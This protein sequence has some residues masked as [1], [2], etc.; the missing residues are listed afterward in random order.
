MRLAF[1]SGIGTGFCAE[2]EQLLMGDFKPKYSR[3]RE[4]LFKEVYWCN[5]KHSFPYLTAILPRIEMMCYR[6]N[7]L[8]E[9]KRR[10][11]RYAIF[12]KMY[13][14]NQGSI[15]L[16]KTPCDWSLED[17]GWRKLI[18]PIGLLRYDTY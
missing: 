6:F 1:L 12:I 14:D 15:C 18:I 7:S 8:A 4:R 2:Q 17:S 13:G 10:S 5:I 16:L 11:Y 3:V 9:H